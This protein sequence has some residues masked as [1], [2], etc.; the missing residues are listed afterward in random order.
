MW[1]YKILT[2]APVLL[3]MA[4]DQG[5]VVDTVEFHQ[6]IHHV[7]VAVPFGDISISASQDETLT[8]VDLQL[9]CR[10]ETPDYSIYVE[11]R[12]LYVTIDAGLDASA[13]GGT[14]FL[15]VPKWVSSSLATDRGKVT[16]S[17]LTGSVDI[18]SYD[19]EVFLNHLSGQVEVTA[20][21]GDVDGV[22]IGRA[23]TT[24]TTGSGDVSLSFDEIPNLVDIDILAGNASLQV[25]ASAYQIDASTGSGHVDLQGVDPA[26]SA[27]NAL[28]LALDA[29][30]IVISGHAR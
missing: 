20:V 7:E 16:A 26:P 1:T 22:G 19:G 13:C 17:G 2:L 10:T 30:D 4:C 21:S 23:T 5:A 12:T 15:A 8:H 6:P 27:P 29:G 18:V 25:P 28:R 11:G 9:E 14:F 24:I 3:M